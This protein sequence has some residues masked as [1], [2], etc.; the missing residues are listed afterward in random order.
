VLRKVIQQKDEQYNRHIIE[1]KVIDPIVECFVA[2]GDRYNLLNSAILEFFEFI[3][4]V[5][6]FCADHHILLLLLGQHLLTYELCYQ[7]SL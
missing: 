4:H 1:R 5:S 7:E 2:N 6:F 3:R